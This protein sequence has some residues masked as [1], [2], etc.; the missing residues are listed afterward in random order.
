MSL[1][2][3]LANRVLEQIEAH[4]ETHN[5]DEWRC[6]TG[7]CFAGWTVQLGGGDRWLTDNT[8]SEFSDL[9]VVPAN[10]PHATAAADMLDLYE[11][12]DDETLA[13]LESLLAST[14]SEYLMTVRVRAQQLL[15]LDTE[16][17]WTLFHG[18]NTLADIKRAINQLSEKE[19]V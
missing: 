17:A 11:G 8:I 14:A 1:N 12:V 13:E 3:D 16:D 2:V 10:T 18:G 6:L 19:A 15:G 5:Q 4:P 9:V 7:M